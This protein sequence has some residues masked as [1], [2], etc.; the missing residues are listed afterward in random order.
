MPN[1]VTNIVRVSGD[2]EK[3]KAMFED[4]NAPHPELTDRNKT[5][6]LK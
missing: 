2:P 4:I 5:N 6:K 1:H 3:V